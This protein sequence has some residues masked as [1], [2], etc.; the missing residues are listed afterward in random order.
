[1]VNQIVRKDNAQDSELMVRVRG[2]TS[3]VLYVSLNGE[4]R[5]IRSGISY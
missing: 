3:E 2:D 1:M 5:Y 4:E